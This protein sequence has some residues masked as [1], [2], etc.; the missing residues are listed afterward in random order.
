MLDTE[1]DRGRQVER[2][3]RTEEI[4]WLT[5]VRCDGQPQPVPVWFLWD[6]A[7]FL[8]YSQPDAQKLRNIKRHPRVALNL[9]SDAQGNQVVRI[10]G[11][12]E[13][14]E[15]APPATGVPEMIE[16]YRAGIARIGMTPEEF[17]RSYSVAIR[18]TPTRFRMY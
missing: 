9:N 12:A 18:V 13:I 15:D 3:L 8:I 14:V 4:I 11:T 7:T 16:K 10:E 1:T 5:T 2:R 17:A 6:G